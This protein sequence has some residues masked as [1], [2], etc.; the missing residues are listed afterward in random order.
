ME[1]LKS[2]VTEETISNQKL[3]QKLIKSKLYIVE[4]GKKVSISRKRS[5][6]RIDLGP[7]RH[8]LGDDNFTRFNLAEKEILQGAAI[9]TCKGNKQGAVNAMKRTLSE[10][11]VLKLNHK[12]QTVT[13][14]RNDHHKR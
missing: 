3:V 7:A 9:Q 4:N 8:R 12:Y 5:T 1:S 2:A 10:Q 6:S 14:S 11:N 13:V